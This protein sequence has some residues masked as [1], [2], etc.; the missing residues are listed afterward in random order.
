MPPRNKSTRQSKARNVA[1][2]G[3]EGSPLPPATAAAQ[4][5][6]PELESLETRPSTPISL[7]R[8]YAQAVASPPSPCLAS[9]SPPSPPVA[10]A[11]SPLSPSLADV[12]HL[13]QRQGGGEIPP[14]PRS[15]SLAVPAAGSLAAVSVD[16]HELTKPGR[17]QGC[18]EAMSTDTRPQIFAHALGAKAKTTARTHQASA[19]ELSA[20]VA[21]AATP[22]LV[23]TGDVGAKLLDDF[24]P[25][26]LL[27]SSIPTTKPP[28]TRT[29]PPAPGPRRDKGKA[30]GPAGPPSPT[31]T[32]AKRAPPSPIPADRGL[33]QH[34]GASPFNVTRHVEQ[35]FG[36]WPQTA[37]TPAQPPHTSTAQ[38]GNDELPT[39]EPKRVRRFPPPF[40]AQDDFTPVSKDLERTRPIFEEPAFLPWMTTPAN[41]NTSPPH[42]GDDS[43]Q[44]AYAEGLLAGRQQNT[45]FGDSELPDLVPISDD[46]D[47]NDNFPSAQP[48]GRPE[49]ATAQ[50]PSSRLP[51][52]TP[53]SGPT[54]AALPETRGERRPRQM[55]ELYPTVLRDVTNTQQSATSSSNHTHAAPPVR[56]Y[57][58]ARPGDL[59]ARKPPNTAWESR[60]SHPPPA[61]SSNVPLSWGMPHAA[62]SN[63]RQ[64]SYAH[65]PPTPYPAV[66]GSSRHTAEYDEPPWLRSPTRQSGQ[67][68]A[69]EI[70]PSSL[71]YAEPAGNV[72]PNH[73]RTYIARLATTEPYAPQPLSFTPRPEEGWETIHRNDPE[74]LIAG[75]CPER[76]RKLWEEEAARTVL[77]EFFNIRYPAPHQVRKMTETLTTIIR[78]ATHETA[79]KII[80]P[81]PAWNADGSRRGEPSAW[82][83]VRLT[84]SG[85]QQL[86][87]RRVLSTPIGTVFTNARAPQIPSYLFTLGGFAHDEDG[88]IIHTVWET[89]NGPQILPAIIR[90]VRGNPAFAN[91]SPE[92]AAGIILS[93]LEVQVSTLDNGNLVAAVFCDSPTA[94][95]SLWRQWRDEMLSIRFQSLFNSTATPRRLTRCVGCH[96]ASHLTHLCP[97]PSVPGWNAPPAVVHEQPNPRPTSDRGFPQ[98][99]PAAPSLFGRG[100][101]GRG[102]GAN[103]RGAPRRRF[104]DRRGPRDEQD[105][106]R[107]KDGFDRD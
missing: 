98:G 31:T 61:P 97:F 16:S 2:E 105:R 41:N 52:W 14:T 57:Y 86:I 36:G 32:P 42:P 81:E 96:S 99:D 104:G 35:T 84:E 62:E 43:V 88:D 85:A 49:A 73:G 68:G 39:R 90:L 56:A 45:S 3:L 95:M 23:T 7:T 24:P 19:V 89:F 92:E 67:P 11:E 63:G 100:A 94:S 82:A 1:N 65:R 9:A 21:E 46:E 91:L 48:T 87:E 58:S 54:N 80:P 106:Y 12:S 71:D 22:T 10:V 40:Y 72:P 37:W 55:P 53:T 74:E 25:L 34:D 78:E 103:S 102:G 69:A 29:A 77:V 30:R 15:T 75:M 50:Q 33:A 83:V 44:R 20:I 28:S 17:S 4:A 59:L 66:P 76:L 26:P 51:H 93:S 47:N 5:T 6:S 13:S 18:V 101:R 8:T 70:V 107:E 27:P 60:S 38:R 79:F 64:R